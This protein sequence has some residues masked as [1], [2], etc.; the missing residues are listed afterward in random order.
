MSE[1]TV[2]P[3]VIMK[4]S[5]GDLTI[6]LFGDKA[7]VTVANF[8]RYVDE[9]FYNGTIF[10]RVIDGFMLQ[11]GGFG[12]DMKQKETHA[13]IRNEA[14]N[15]L[16][17]GRGTLAMARTNVVDS[18]TAQFFINVVDN[19]FLDHKTPDAQGFGYCVFGEVTAGLET[20]DAI[21]KVRTG[22]KGGFQDVPVETV[23]ILE[24]R[25]TEPAA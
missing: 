22:N 4:T 17:N 12:K 19:A 25:R 1:P 5:K 18:A 9:G 21:R 14:K 3:T 20:V 6:R 16:K 8:L 13:P 11:G 24:V 7:P 23:E 15:G 2:N 10:H